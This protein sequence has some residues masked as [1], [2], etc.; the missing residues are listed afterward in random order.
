VLLD[1]KWEDILKRSDFGRPEKKKSKEGESKSEIH[2]LTKVTKK[3]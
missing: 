2:K 3:K 1:S